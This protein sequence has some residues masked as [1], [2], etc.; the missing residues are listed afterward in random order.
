MGASGFHISIL[1]GWCRT[2]RAS[3][4]SKATSGIEGWWTSETKPLISSRVEDWISCPAFP[5]TKQC[6]QNVLVLQIIK[7]RL[8]ILGARQYLTMS[9]S[10]KNFNSSKHILLK[11]WKVLTSYLD[12]FIQI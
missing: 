7:L 10:N 6:D 2:S 12:F 9:E 4:A 11:V 1:S 5:W 8:L 3:M